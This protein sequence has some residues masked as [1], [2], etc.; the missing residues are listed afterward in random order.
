M[1][2]LKLTPHDDEKKLD[3][4]PNIDCCT[5]VFAVENVTIMTMLTDCH[6]TENDEIRIIITQSYNNSLM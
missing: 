2:S 5:H 1:C 4:S 3:L 6:T